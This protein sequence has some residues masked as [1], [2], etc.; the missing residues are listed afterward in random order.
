MSPEQQAEVKNILID[1]IKQHP[2]IYDKAYPLH[3]WTNASNKVWDE[4][5]KILNIPGKLHNFS[6]NLFFD[7][8][9]L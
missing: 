9:I 5:G 1:L 6:L 3:Y 2:L 4:I 7:G 8:T